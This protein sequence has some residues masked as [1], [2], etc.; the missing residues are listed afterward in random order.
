MAKLCYYAAFQH[1][2]PTTKQ[3]V[4]LHAMLLNLPTLL[5]LLCNVC[6][7]MMSLFDELDQRVIDTAVMQ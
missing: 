2:I 6:V 4:M 5:P 3:E 7:S 1:K